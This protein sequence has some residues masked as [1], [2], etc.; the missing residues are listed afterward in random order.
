MAGNEDSSKDE[1]YTDS[2]TTPPTASGSTTIEIPHSTAEAVEDSDNLQDIPTKS[3]LAPEIP[4]LGGST[5]PDQTT[6]SVS[7][8]QHSDS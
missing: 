3:Q 5:P 1:E 6:D 7:I 2:L 4:C 8:Q